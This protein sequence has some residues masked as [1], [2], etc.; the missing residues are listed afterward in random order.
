MTDGRIESRPHRHRDVTVN[1][2]WITTLGAIL[3]LIFGDLQLMRGIYFSVWGHFSEPIPIHRDFLGIFTATFTVIACA[4]LFMFA[5]TLRKISLKVACA[6][7]G[8]DLVIDVLLKLSWVPQALRRD[9]VVIT[10]LMFQAALL[11][12]LGALAKWLVSVVRLR[13]FG[14]H[15]GGDH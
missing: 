15:R 1:S 7:M 9:A 8:L 6:L 10:T 5:F 2:D 14:E 12:F 13:T 3:P 11:I 4:Y